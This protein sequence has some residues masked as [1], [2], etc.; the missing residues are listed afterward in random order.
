MLLLSELEGS[1]HGGLLQG[2]DE[3]DEEE[4]AGGSD[5]RVSS[6]SQAFMAACVPQTKR[7]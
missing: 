1:F 5:S 2:E 3:E 4:E 6:S 7:I